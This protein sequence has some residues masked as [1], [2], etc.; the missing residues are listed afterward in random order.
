MRNLI[1][2][3]IFAAAASSLADDFPSGAIETARESAVHVFGNQR[4]KGGGV[5]VDRD[6]LV[7][8]ACH[9]ADGTNMTFAVEYPGGQRVPVRV[10]AVDVQADLMLLTPAA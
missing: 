8:T 3:L 2:P 9:L 5:V 4:T 10:L 1:L 6:G 7:L